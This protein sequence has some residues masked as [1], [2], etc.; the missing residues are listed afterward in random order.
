M[1]IVV[2]K[3]GLELGINDAFKEMADADTDGFDYT[4]GSVHGLKVRIIAEP[5]GNCEIIVVDGVL[6]YTA[7]AEDE[8]ISPCTR[9]ADAGR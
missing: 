4:I 6:N 2:S 5:D 1:G 3:K 8:S 9:P 7:L